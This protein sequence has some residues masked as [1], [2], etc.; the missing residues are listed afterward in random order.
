ML[1]VMRKQPV[2]PASDRGQ[3]NRHIGGMANEVAAGVNDSGGGIGND[4]WVRQLEQPMILLG[5]RIDGQGWQPFG[6]DSEV[7]LDF[8][9]NH[10]CQYQLAN[11]CGAERHGSFVEAPRGNNSRYQDIGVQKQAN[12]PPGCHL[13]DIARERSR[14]LRL[15]LTVFP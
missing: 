10:C 5:Q 8:I 14:P 11:S 3:Q 4:Y 2:W 7:L 15:E 13:P 6:M 9:A 12:F 1:G